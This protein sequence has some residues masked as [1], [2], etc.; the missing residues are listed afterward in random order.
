MSMSDEKRAALI[1]MCLDAGVMVQLDGKFGRSEYTSVQSSWP[2]LEKLATSVAGAAINDLQVN[3][4]FEDVGK[5]VIASQ[6]V[7]VKRTEMQD[8]GSLTAIIDYW[9]MNRSFKG[10]ITGEAAEILSDLLCLIDNNLKFGCVPMA[11]VRAKALYR[12][13]AA[14]KEGVKNAE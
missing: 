13:L 12:I 11:Y 5:D 1:Q 3:A 2:A 4:M 7:S 10:E 6:Y 9:P 14:N 8:D